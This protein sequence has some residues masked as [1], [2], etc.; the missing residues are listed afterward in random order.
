MVY[1][2]V[3]FVCIEKQRTESEKSTRRVQKP[4]RREINGVVFGVENIR[5]EE[6]TQ[7]N[8]VGKAKEEEERRGRER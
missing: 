3:W 7:Q 2:Y 1:S 6:A 4:H 8:W 5:A